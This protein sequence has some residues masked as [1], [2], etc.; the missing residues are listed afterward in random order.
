MWQCAACIGTAPGGSNRMAVFVAIDSTA[1][2]EGETDGIMVGL[3]DGW[4]VGS[5]FERAPHPMQDHTQV[6]GCGIAEVIGPELITDVLARQ[7]VAVTIDEQEEELTGALAAP[8]CG[9][10]GGRSEATAKRAEGLDGQWGRP[11]GAG[12][13][14]A[15]RCLK[16]I[17]TSWYVPTSVC[18]IPKNGYLAYPP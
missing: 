8:L 10:D 14:G 6:V 13:G 15:A 16:H 3:D 4:C 5:G 17:T 9:G 2:G 18:R 12:F 11:I 1:V 7:A